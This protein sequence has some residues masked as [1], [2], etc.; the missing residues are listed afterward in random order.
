VKVTVDQQRPTPHI[1]LVI[2]GTSLLPVRSLQ[3]APDARH[4][5]IQKP[6]RLPQ[7]KQK[8]KTKKK[9]PRLP[10]AQDENGRIPYKLTE[11]RLLGKNENGKLHGKNL[12]ET[13]TDSGELFSRPFSRIPYFSGN[14]PAVEYRIWYSQQPAAQ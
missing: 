4:A 8:Q 11:Y 12:V 9:K 10:T 5:C 3:H 13:G 6:C 1:S 7:R 2:H 14:I